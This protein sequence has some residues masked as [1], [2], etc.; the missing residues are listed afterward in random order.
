MSGGSGEQALLSSACAQMAR[1]YDLIGGAA[2]GMCD[3]KLPDMQAG[4]ERGISNVMTGLSGLNFNYESVGMYASLLG[5][6]LESLIID[7]DLLGQALRCVRGIEVTEDS[8]SIEAIRQVTIVGPG[9]YLG[10]DQ[11]I[12]LMQ[13]EYVYPVLGDRTSPKEWVEKGKPD[14][15]QEAIRMKN[16]ILATRFPTHISDAVDDRIRADFNI[17]LPRDNVGRGCVQ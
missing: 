3:A 15:I 1:F 6:S 4:Y 2:T 14:L 13:T 17:V 8:L 16:E 5:F 11:T 7:N 12:S 10:H 9:H